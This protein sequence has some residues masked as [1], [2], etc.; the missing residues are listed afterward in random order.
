MAC[1]VGEG[2]KITTPEVEDL[3]AKTE[4]KKYTLSAL[5]TVSNLAQY[6]LDPPRGSHQ[7]ALVSISGK[8]DETYIIENVVLLSKEDSVKVKESLKYLMQLAMHIF[9][10]DRKRKVEWNENY[11]PFA[12][13]RACTR[14]GRAPSDAP[15]P[16]V[17][18]GGG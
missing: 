16:A 11:S 8:D 5:C 17:G 10:R 13:K 1:N 3:L 4:G 9:N 6:K 2:F 14:M 7:D 12:N 15:L 18:V